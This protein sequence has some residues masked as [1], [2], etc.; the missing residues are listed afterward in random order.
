MCPP[1]RSGALQNWVVLG[2]VDMEEYVDAHM[3][4]VADWELNLRVLKAAAKDAE[5]LPNEVGHSLW[6]H[7]PCVAWC[8]T[9]RCPCMQRVSHN[10]CLALV[11]VVL[12]FGSRCSPSPPWLSLCLQ[13]PAGLLSHQ[14]AAAEEFCW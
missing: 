12:L 9:E 11:I 7:A 4:E 10:C 13:G 3:E 8:T 6:V 14:P 2:S 5:R 1:P